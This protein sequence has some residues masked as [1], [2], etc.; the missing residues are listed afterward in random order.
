[1][2]AETKQ[3]AAFPASL[4]IFARVERCLGIQ[5]GFDVYLRPHKA[6]ATGLDARCHPLA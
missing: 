4:A 6:S 5:H 1:M 2:N 3:R